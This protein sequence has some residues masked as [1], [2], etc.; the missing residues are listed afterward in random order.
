MA[1]KTNIISVKV[2]T[3]TTGTTSIILDGFNWAVND[4]VSKNRAARSVINLSLGGAASTTWTNAIASSYEQGVLS[5]VAAGNGNSAGVAIPVANASPANAPNA[6]T[7]GAADSSFKI[8]VFS[9]YGAGVDVIA[10]GVAILSSYIGSDTAT[11]SLSGTSMATPHTV[12]LALYLISLENLTTP[13]DVTDR[14]KALAV[15]GKVTGN[16]QGT[17]NLFIYNGNGA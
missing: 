9:N 15:S 3:G 14:I 12:G 16:L 5:V 1:K 2:F 11:A 13:A 6:L 4:I 7:V 17:P 8:G 10:P